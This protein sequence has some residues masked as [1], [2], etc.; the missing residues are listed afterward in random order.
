MPARYLSLDPFILWQSAEHPLDWR[1]RFGREALL[2]LEIGFG[3]G[4]FLVQQA[5][6]A[7]ERNFVG[8]EREW[9]S[10][11]RGLRRIAQAKVANVRLLLADARVALERLF[12]PHALDRVTCLFPCPWPKER[13]SKHRLFSHAFLRLLNG[14]LRAGGEAHIVTDH[15][16][17]AQWILAE[18]LDTGFVTHC[19]QIAPHFSTKYERKWQAQGQEQF[20]ELRL[21]AGLAPD[22]SVVRKDVRMQTHRIPSFRPERFQPTGWRGDVAIEFK[23]FLFD[24]QRQRGM[25]W[26]FVT[27]DSLEQNFWIEIAH[28]DEHWY[29][30]PA[31]GCVVVPTVG[32]QRALDLVRAAALQQ[33]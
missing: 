21:Q 22:I 5:R 16:V 6:Q 19:Q 17:Y 12:L 31:R 2:E 26:V 11:Q 33:T 13:H 14:R 24:P 4:E 18:A 9:A 28:G 25:V 7:P 20:Y 8:I 32:V 10:I 30:R 3:N 23:D 29:I 1:R 27:E 15:P